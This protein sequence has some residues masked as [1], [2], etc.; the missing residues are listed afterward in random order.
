MRRTLVKISTTENCITFRTISR[1]GKSRQFY[2]TRS[3]FA[4]L[5]YEPEIITRDIWSFAVLRRDKAKDTL[6][7]QF[8][9]LSGD[10]TNVKGSEEKVTLRYSELAAF[11]RANEGEGAE[12]RAL[13]LDWRA[14]R[15]RL[16]FS[17]RENLHAAVSNGTVR[18]KLSRALR[19]NFQWPDAEQIVLSN[20]F[21]PYS[22]FFREMRNGQQVMCGG[23]ILHGQENMSKAYYGLHT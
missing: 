18:R 10:G 8:T 5:E 15:P 14:H 13:S 11:V 21:V 7:V 4:K 1:S 12:Y 19:D 6:S 16:V 3:E 23:L 9:W 17:G 2:V 22:F 20:D